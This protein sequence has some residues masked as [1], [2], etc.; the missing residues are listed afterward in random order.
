MN[1]ATKRVKKAARKDTVLLLIFLIFV[2]L[3]KPILIYKKYPMAPEI[4]GAVFAVVND[5]HND[6]LTIPSNPPDK[7]RV[8][9]CLI[10]YNNKKI[11]TTAAH[12][13]L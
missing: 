1:R 4:F 10:P 5:R 7:R 8:F 9:F 12:R 6:S 3:I 13:G 2:S 11:S